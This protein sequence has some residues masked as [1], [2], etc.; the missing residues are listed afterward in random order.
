MFSNKQNINILTS[1]LIAHGIENAVV[2]PGSRNAPIVHNL[3][4]CDNI[5]CW[6]VTDERSA[7]FYAI[8]MAQAT[9]KPVVVCVTS[10]SALLNLAPAIAEAHYQHI[11]LIVVSADRPQ[12]WI[13]Q[14]DGQTLPQPDALQPFVRKAVNLPEPHDDETRWLCNRLINE[15][16]F[17]SGVHGFTPV[18]I[19]VPISEPLFTFD[20]HELPKER[21]FRPITRCYS[22]AIPTLLLNE[23]SNAQHPLI[24]I[25]QTTKDAI[26]TQT[27]E[28]LT[29]VV[30]V[31][32]E[33]LS[34]NSGKTLLF[35]EVIRCSQETDRLMPDLIIYVGDTLVSKA[36]RRFLRNSEARTYLITTDASTT[37]DP[38]MWLEGIV[39]CADS[40]DI[41][42]LLLSLATVFSNDSDT[43]KKLFHAVWRQ[44]LANATLHSKAFIPPFSQMSSV[45]CLEE[46][47]GCGSNYIH[48]HYANS[49]AIRLANI[50]AKHYVWCNRGVNGIEG[51]ISTAAGF[52]LATEGTVVCVTGDLSFFYD[53]NALWNQCIDGR[54]R[55]LLLNNGGGG[56]FR[57]LKGLQSSPAAERFIE[58]SH[59]ATAQGICLQNG[60]A[61]ASAHNME[62]MQTEID[63]LLTQKSARPMLLEVFTDA[64]T[65]ASTLEEYYSELRKGIKKE[66]KKT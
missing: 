56:I 3:N 17:Q 6:P 55:I 21:A 33:P 16:L 12:Q 20:T 15:A 9:Q 8:G 14:L 48:T 26:S 57:Q 4:E 29:N 22:H 7:G 53:Q 37:P 35:D 1:L 62:E 47:I 28:V 38:T 61:Y 2:C 60:I 64:E 27:M 11:P 10:G 43:E 39:E 54:L 41:N 45:K 34:N 50:Y 66:T 32:S 44:S 24:V 36:A 30:T 42:R 63:C 49:T 19:N 52:S 40:Q 51:S 31:F 46:R 25:G 23:T 58:A 13:G 18:H 59:S 5:K 65:D